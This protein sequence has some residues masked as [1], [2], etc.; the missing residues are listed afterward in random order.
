[1]TSNSGEDN[2]NVSRNLDKT[3]INARLK[4]THGCS[5]IDHL[6]L[7]ADVFVFI[8]FLGLFEGEDVSP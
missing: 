5:L 8:R 2:A 3:K 1:M 6:P 7:V 4:R